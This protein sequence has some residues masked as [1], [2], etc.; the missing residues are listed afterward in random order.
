M[1]AA[2]VP[3]L[4]RAERGDLA[5]VARMRA[6][7]AK[8]D[9]AAREAE[10]A[11]QLEAD[12]SAV[13]PAKDSRWADLKEAA[14]AA[15]KAADEELRRRCIAAGIPEEFRP[16]LGV[17]WAGRGENGTAKRR[18]ELRTL[19]RAQI[20][21]LGKRAKVEI[22]RTEADVCTRILADGLRS[23]AARAALADIPT[24]ETLMPPLV[25]VELEAALPSKGARL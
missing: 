5:K 19:G 9:V 3:Q 25:L 4:T 24:P 2:N 14:D 15:A 21:A 12:L 6:R 20:A 23:D 13:Y 22:E 8:S 1:S 7:V 17:W 16:S 11:A 18:A 10:L